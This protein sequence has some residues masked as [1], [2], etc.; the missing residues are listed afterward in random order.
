MKVLRQYQLDLIFLFFALLVIIW[1]LFFGL[2][3]LGADPHDYEWMIVGPLLLVYC[4]WM[5]GVR[6]SIS[7]RERRALTTKSL[8][9]WIALGIAIIA[10]YSTPVPASDYWSINALFLVFTLFLADSYW[11]FTA[12]TAEGLFRK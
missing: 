9:Y 7:L 8:V 12:L 5:F 6:N 10:S 2:E 4:V 1:A 3:Y 11:D